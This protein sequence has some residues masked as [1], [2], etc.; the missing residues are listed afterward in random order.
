[1]TTLVNKVDRYASECHKDFIQSEHHEEMHFTPSGT[2]AVLVLPEAQPGPYTFTEWSRSQLLQHLG[3]REKWFASVSPA[4]EVAELTARLHTL[5]D[6]VIRRRTYKTRS[7][8]GTESTNHEIRGFV[9]KSYADIPDAVIVRALEDVCGFDAWVVSRYTD[10]TD[11]ALYAYVVSGVELGL[12]GTDERVFAGVQV[13][14]SEV[15]YS[16]LRVTPV[17]YFGALSTPV[18]INEDLVFRKV[19]RGDHA[20]LRTQFQAAI[21]KA[22]TIC[23]DLVQKTRGLYQLTYPDADNAVHHLSLALTRA[24]AQKSFIRAVELVYR[25]DPRQAHDGKRIFDAVV[26]VVAEQQDNNKVADLATVAGAVLVGLL[27]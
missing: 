18:V 3:T 21:E 17:L 12:P 8:D 22:K 23:G 1:M 7:A 26:A 25:K 27:R 11:R 24:G 13:Q 4:Q 9:S 15:G 6:S 5:S 14:N 16:S 10:K 20:L 19:H 2:T